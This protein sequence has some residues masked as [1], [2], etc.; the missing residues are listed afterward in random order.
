VS[1]ESFSCG[2]FDR[3]LGLWQYKQQFLGGWVTASDDGIRLERST[4]PRGFRLVYEFEWSEISRIRCTTLVA[5]RWLSVSPRPSQENPFAVVQLEIREGI[6]IHS[7]G[8]LPRFVMPWPTPTLR[9]AE[10]IYARIPAD[11]DHYW[12]S[13]AAFLRPVYHPPEV[14]L[15][16]W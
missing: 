14:L 16:D 6:K 3:Q 15:Y 1:S 4:F 12:C 10:R 13:E 7:W 11:V 8:V 5:S 9:A 2:W